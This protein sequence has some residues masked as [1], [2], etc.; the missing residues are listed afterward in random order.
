M[1]RPRLG[2]LLLGPLGPEGVLPLGPLRPE[3]VVLR[4]LRPHVRRDERELLAVV[5][6]GRRQ[7]VGTAALRQLTGRVG[8]G[9]PDDRYPQR[10]VGLGHLVD[11]RPLAVR[12]G[13]IP[14]RLRRVP[15]RLRRVPVGLRPLSVR[16]RHRLV[17]GQ[18]LGGVPAE[19]LLGGARREAGEH[20]AAVVA[21]QDRADGDVAVGP[22]VRVEHPQGGE[23]VGADLGGP[24]GVEGAFGE[25][26][27]ERAGRDELADYPERTG[28]GEHVEDLVEPGVVGHLGGGLRGLD[29]PPD[30]GVRT[31]AHRSPGGAPARRRTAVGVEHLGVHDLRQRHL[32]DQDLLAAVRVERPGLDQF[33]PIG[34]GQRQAV[35]VGKHPTRVVVHDASPERAVPPAICTVRISQLWSFGGQLTHCSGCVRSPSSYDT[36]QRGP[37]GR[38]V[39]TRP[40]QYLS[41]APPDG[42]FVGLNVANAVSRSVRHSSPSHSSTLQLI[43]IE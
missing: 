2:H 35:A 34:R 20:D 8:A 17:V 5:A 40:T 26:G 4:Q 14:V 28:L 21:D 15:V 29:R 10:V 18:R 23:H 9:R 7:G 30:R 19:R 22:A 25:E 38:V 32:A 24:V 37:L 13:R 12:L 6:P 36:W 39:A 27:G 11:P 16:L 41:P 43:M 1:G 42:Y 33:V 3:R 31:A